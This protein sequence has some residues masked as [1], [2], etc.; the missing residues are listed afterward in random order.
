MLGSKVGRKHSFLSTPSARRA[1]H[2]F[3]ISGAATCY[4]YPRPPRGGR[5]LPVCSPYS[6]AQF[7]ST[8]SARRATRQLLGMKPSKDPFLST[9]SARRATGQTRCRRQART[10]SIHALRKE[11]DHSQKRPNTRRAEF[12]STP[13][14]RRA[15]RQI[16]QVP[17]SSC[18][19]YPRPPQG[20]RHFSGL[21][22][23]TDP[24][25]YPRPPRGGRL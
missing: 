8:P 20:G 16:Q 4:F 10:I 3:A 11:G 13:S 18:H 23:Y 1:T 6:P 25:F 24:N 9:P 12:L 17:A 15:T 5:R 2:L 19:F 7:L 14:A 22:I 21:H